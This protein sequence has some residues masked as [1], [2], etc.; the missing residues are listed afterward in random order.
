M[1][2]LPITPTTGTP[3][4]TS[5]SNSM[6]AKPNAPSPSSRQTWRSG[7]A[8]F[9]AKAKPG[10]EPRQPD[11][12]GSIQQPGSEGAARPRVQPGAR[13][14][15]VDHAPGVGDEVPAVADHDRVAVEHLLQ[16]VVEAH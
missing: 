13:L 9:A 4:R 5:V 7:C 10:P 15:G 12:P 16:L 11:G 2:L 3:C 6:P 14:V 8:S 1:P